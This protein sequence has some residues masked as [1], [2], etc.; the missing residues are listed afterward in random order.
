LIRKDR[1]GK[2][3]EDVW[4]K[5][6]PSREKVLR[7]PASG[8]GREYYSEF[9]WNQPMQ[10]TEQG[11]EGEEARMSSMVGKRREEPCTSSKSKYR[12]D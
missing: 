2:I 6:S 12:E 1:E 9:F 10:A 8:E 7:P 3:G 4:L 11:E 5:P